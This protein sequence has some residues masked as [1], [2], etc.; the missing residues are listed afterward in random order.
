MQ[1]GIISTRTSNGVTGQNDAYLRFFSMF[2][3][4]IIQIDPLNE[5]VYDNL[6]LLVLPGGPDVDP[7]RYGEKP[8]R[9][10]GRPNPQTEWFDRVMLP[11]YIARKIPTF[12]ICRG[13]QSLV[14][15]FGGKINQHIN[16]DHSTKSRAELVDVMNIVTENLPFEYKDKSVK[17]NSI[18]HQAANA[19]SLKNTIM[20]PLGFERTYKNIEALAYGDLPI[21]SVQWHPEECYDKFAIACVNYLLNYNQ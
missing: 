11:K 9:F 6:N 10:T 20:R 15:H 5:V 18:H 3:D 14:V 4:N 17:I 1:I 7:Q 12:G 21:L 16:V 8:S 2:T 19:E 13:H